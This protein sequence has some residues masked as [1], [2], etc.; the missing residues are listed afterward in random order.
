[1]R[2]AQIID[3]LHVGG[4]ERMAVNYANA[5]EDA[6]DFSGLVTTRAEGELKNQ[7]ENK[8]RYLFL[9]KKSALDIKA[10]FKLRQY[11]K[12][13]QVNVVHAHGTSFF[14][15][16]LLKL[17]HPNIKIV[18][19][20]HLGARSAEN[21][22]QN[23]SLWIC[24]RFFSG[25]IAVDHTLEAW[26]RE[27][28][29]FNNVIYLPNFTLFN[30]NE[31]PKTKLKGENGKRIL[32]LANLRQPKN[33]HM[34][35]EAASIVNEKFP[36][37]TF[38][39]VG[40]DFNDGYSKTLKELIKDKHLKETVYIYGLCEDTGSITEQS[41]IAVLTS[42]SEGLP[43]ALLEYG[44]H[45]KAVVATNVGEI[46]LIID[47]QKNGYAVSSGDVEM[48]AERLISLIENPGQRKNFGEALNK[49]IIKNHSK[50][51]VIGHYLNWIN[52]I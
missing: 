2:I 34:L 22:K 1:M 35:V 19:H 17:I 31:T 29:N 41:S 27:K 15:A 49:T 25:I 11:C 5:L 28:L 12:D 16:F 40:N 30:N 33:H 14:I 23:P 7:I 52:K 39:L 36:D 38:H 42:T 45:K 46:P 13:N 8:F 43:V 37:W 24:S 18:W 9:E 48:F 10:V 50:E 6:I 4:A 3:S 26:C 51:A 44:M 47:N 21:A 32:C 20:E